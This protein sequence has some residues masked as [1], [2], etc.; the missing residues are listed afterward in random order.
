MDDILDTKIN[1]SNYN[2]WSVHKAN[3]PHFDNKWMSWR[4]IDITHNALEVHFEC[5]ICG[6]IAYR[7]YEIVCEDVF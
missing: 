5:G 3:G 2:D 4:F 6:Q 1:G 7:T